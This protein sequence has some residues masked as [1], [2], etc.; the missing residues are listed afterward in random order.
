MIITTSIA[1][2]A[3]SKIDTSYT[4][5]KWTSSTITKRINII[6]SIFITRQAMSEIQTVQAILYGTKLTDTSK[7]EMIVIYS[8]TD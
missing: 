5:L 1:G 7:V 3:V 4:V 6:S 8:I 2:F